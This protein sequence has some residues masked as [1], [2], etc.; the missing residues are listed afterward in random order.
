MT[1][2]APPPSPHPWL[3]LAGRVLWRMVDGEQEVASAAL[4]EMV[5]EHG[6]DAVV[7]AMQA[8]AD[9]ALAYRPPPRPG[10]PFRLGFLNADTGRITGADEVA[11]AQA[12]AGQLIAARAADDHSMFRALV[13][14]TRDTE[15]WSRRVW[16]LLHVCALNIRAARAAGV[17]PQL[18]PDIGQR[19][20]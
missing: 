3:T 11:P 6:A 13:E 20:P 1:P 9:T 14:S 8:W 4:Q 19:T 12:W 18:W 7:E 2:S 10:Q 16:A 17:Q 5:L 15:E